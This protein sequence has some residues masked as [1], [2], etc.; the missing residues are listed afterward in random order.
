ML[1]VFGSTDPS[2]MPRHLFYGSLHIDFSTAV[3]ADVDRQNYT[4]CP[5]HWYIDATFQCRRCNEKFIFS[6]EEQEYWYEEL[7]FWIDSSAKNCQKCRSE[8]RHLKLLRQE[9]DR[10]IA[11]ALENTISIDRKRRVLEVIEALTEGGVELPDRMQ[12]HRLILQKQ[13]ANN[14]S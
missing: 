4:V 8:L 14:V 3:R 6:A 1:D 11:Q 12:R 9:Y 5:R 10:D 13:I 7:G 2:K